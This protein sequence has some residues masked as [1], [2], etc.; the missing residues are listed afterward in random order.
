MDDCACITLART[1]AGYVRLCPAG[2]LHVTYGHVTLH[3]ESEDDFG[4]MAELVEAEEHSRKPDE[5]LSVSYQ[6][7]SVDLDAAHSESFAALIAS[8]AAAIA[9]QR[10]EAQFTDADFD[11]LVGRPPREP[12][13]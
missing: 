5:G 12:E 4:G 11:S 7:F 9:W 2:C 3:F 6:W 1:E 10:G 8:A 13:R